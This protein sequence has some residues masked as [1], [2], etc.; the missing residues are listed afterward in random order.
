VEKDGGSLD[1]VDS[2]SD[3]HGSSV[4]KN[5]FSL[6]AGYPF[7]INTFVCCQDNIMEGNTKQVIRVAPSLNNK[8]FS[9]SSLALPKQCNHTHTHS[10]THDQ[11]THLLSLI[12]IRMCPS[13]LIN[14]VNTPILLPT[15]NPIQ[16][17]FK[18]YN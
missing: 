6:I 9:L 15:T 3:S 1:R 4:T 11:Q 7:G 13:K 8:F 16:I 2:G 12:R 5:F 10:L 18:L 17:H 14:R